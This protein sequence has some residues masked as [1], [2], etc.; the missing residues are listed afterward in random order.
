[1]AQI[2]SAFLAE[3]RNFILANQQLT[4]SMEGM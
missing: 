2:S 3:E 1:M 4:Q